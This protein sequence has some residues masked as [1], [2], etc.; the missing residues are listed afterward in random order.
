MAVLTCAMTV[1]FWK[2]QNWARIV[3]L[4]LITLSLVLMTT[5]LRPLL[6][7]PTAVAIILTL[8]RVALSAFWL[9]YLLRRP[10]RDVFRREAAQLATAHTRDSEARW[11]QKL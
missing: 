5:E 6:S 7:A 8:V 10:V 3:M 1:G 9:W 4:A 2:L 11:Q